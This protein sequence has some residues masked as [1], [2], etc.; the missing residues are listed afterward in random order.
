MLTALPMAADMPRITCLTVRPCVPDR[1][2]DEAVA[3]MPG[4]LAGDHPAVIEP[5]VAGLGEAGDGMGVAVP[6][7]MVAAQRLHR[8]GEADHVARRQGRLSR[9]GRARISPACSTG[10]LAGSVDDAAA[11]PLTKPPLAF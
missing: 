4:L 2:L 7:G 11:A 6:D 1:R 8:A 3:E 10:T 9:G 5:D